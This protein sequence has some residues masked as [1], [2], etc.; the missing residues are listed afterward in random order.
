M[1]EKIKITV[2]PPSSHP[3]FFTVQD[4]LEQVLD[5]FRLALT[6]EKDSLNVVWKLTDVSMNSPLSATA[7]AISYDPLINIDEPARKQKSKLKR[8][9]ESVLKGI[10]PEEWASDEGRD[11]IDRLLSRN[12]NGIGKTIIVVDF[13]KDSKPIE[14]TQPL[15]VSARSEIRKSPFYLVSEEFPHRELGSID[16]YLIAVGSHYGKPA[17]QVKD[18]LTN[19][20][21]WCRVPEET[22]N[23][24][25]KSMVL[26]DIWKH[27]RVTVSG[28]I[29]YEKNGTIGRIYDA[30][31][32]LMVTKEI[33]LDEVR[34]ESFTHGMS[35][36]EYLTKLREGNFD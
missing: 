32:E 13:A 22:V 16:G 7:E 18:R 8:G 30:Q 14:V 23:S 6:G 19:E 28:S 21:I 35:P 10:I 20:E 12:N 29:Q 34:D 15:A 2:E 17:I 24:I 4:A 31:I 5:C 1:A 27:K 9:V 36:T 25:S 33:S 26:D 3:E 11:I